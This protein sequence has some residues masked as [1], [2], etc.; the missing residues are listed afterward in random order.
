MVERSR[1]ARDASR[2]GEQ[3]AQHFGGMLREFRE[4]YFERISR[5]HGV[6]NVKMHLTA[7]AL[8]EC[9]RERGYPISSGAYSMV[10]AGATMPKDPRRFISAISACLDLDVD[11]IRVLTEQVA[12][13]IL[14]ARLG[15]EIA[16]SAFPHARRA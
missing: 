8:I 3:T 4:T 9:M 1:S 11:Q 10:E 5:K 12:H 13:D 16:R 6:P 2:Q 7:L 14:V 15:E